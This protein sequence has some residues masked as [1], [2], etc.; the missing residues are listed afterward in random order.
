MRAKNKKI[1][2]KVIAKSARIKPDFLSHIVRG[3]KRCPRDVALRLEQVTGISKVVWVWGK[4]EEIREA[5]RNFKNIMP[6]EDGH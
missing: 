1:T 2:Q 3:R 5:L 6:N 4:P